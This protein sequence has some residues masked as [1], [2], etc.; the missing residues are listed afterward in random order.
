MYRKQRHD[1]I[2]VIQADTSLLFWDSFANESNSSFG[3]LFGSHYPSNEVSG[4]FSTIKDKE[5]PEFSN[6]EKEVE[7]ENEKLIKSVRV[8]FSSEN[9]NECS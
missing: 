9:Q 2:I 1:T 5:S 3:S 4:I 8:F 7:E 6:G